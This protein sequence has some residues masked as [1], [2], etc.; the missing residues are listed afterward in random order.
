MLHGDVG[1]NLWHGAKGLIAR[2]LGLGLVRFYPETRD[3]LLDR[4]LPHVAEEGTVDRGGGGGHVVGVARPVHV[5]HHVGLPRPR[6]AG[7]M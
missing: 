5:V 6:H 2:F 3:L 1:H 4:G 7:L